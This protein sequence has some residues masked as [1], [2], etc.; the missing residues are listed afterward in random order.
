M[1][2][3]EQAGLIFPS[4]PNSLFS[5]PGFYKSLKESFKILPNYQKRLLCIQIHSISQKIIK[6]HCL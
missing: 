2:K 6:K 1:K 5:T 4:I 3:V